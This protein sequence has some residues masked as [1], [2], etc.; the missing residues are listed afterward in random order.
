MCGHLKALLLTFF[1]S[2]C[3]LVIRRDGDHGSLSHPHALCLRLGLFTPHAIHDAMVRSEPYSYASAARLYD[4]SPLETSIL[5]RGSVYERFAMLSVISL[6][7]ATRS[8]IATP[9]R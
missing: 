7:V 1:Y 6:H 8:L 9:A 5:T 3:N 4:L 2:S